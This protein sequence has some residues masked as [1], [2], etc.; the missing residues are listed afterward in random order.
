MAMGY[1]DAS[2]GINQ[3]RSPRIP[4]DEFATFDGFD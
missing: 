4:T 2:A 3:W 1:A